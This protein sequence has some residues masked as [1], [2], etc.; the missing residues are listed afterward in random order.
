[1]HN[2]GLFFERNAGDIADVVRAARNSPLK[3][4]E[5][6][7]LRRQLL[8][9][10]DTVRKV[11]ELYEKRVSPEAMKRAVK[12]VEPYDPLTPPTPP[13]LIRRTPKT[14]LTVEKG[15]V[16]VAEIP[17]E[18]FGRMTREQIARLYLL[19][20]AEL[21]AAIGKALPKTTEAVR[22]AE[23]TRP[24]VS[25]WVTPVPAVPP[26]P[27]PKPVPKPRPRPKPVPKPKPKPV[28]KPTPKP[29]PKP[30]PK[31]E[32]VPRA[33]PKPVPKPAPKPVPKPVPKPTPK[34]VPRPK[35]IPKPVP[36]PKPKLLPRLIPSKKTDKEKRKIIRDSKG[37]IAWRHGELHGRD[38]FHVGVYPY[39]S[40]EHYLTVVGRKPAGATIIKGVGSAR[41]SIRL[42]YGKS[43]PKTVTG[44]LGFFDFA[45]EP[46]GPKTVDIR[47]TPDPK[48]ETTGDI[49][50][51]RRMPR[52]TPKTPRLRR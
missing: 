31:P 14:T 9:S 51:G 2:R 47:F 23:R 1:M 42:L 6:E 28:P 52:I 8:K 35:P 7:L 25:P 40:E 33:V 43:P 19:A 3:P 22:Q 27:V 45:I 5:V 11:G 48:M 34:P 4:R 10:R 26:K 12:I 29:V 18:A 32:P 17:V 50:I 24:V 21:G 13:G 30:A 36:K 44:D 15:G 16:T 20:P 49:R 39:T 46:T 37:A 41:Q 38:V